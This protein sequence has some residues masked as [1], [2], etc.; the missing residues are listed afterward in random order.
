MLKQ[1][2]MAN[3]TAFNK[4]TLCFGQHLNVI[5]GENGLRKTHLLKLAYAI[6]AVSAEEKRKSK[7]SPPTKSLL[8]TRYAEKLINVFRPEVLGRLAHLKRSRECCD[9]HLRFEDSTLDTAF[10]FATNSKTEVNIDTLPTAW[11]GIAPTYLL[12][13]EL[14]TIFLNFVSAYEGHYFEFEETW[15][16]IEVRNYRIHSRTKPTE[17]PDE[18]AQ[19]I[20]DT[21][22]AL[23]PAKLPANQAD[24]KQLA[25]AIAAAKALRVVLHL[26]QPAKHSRLRL[27]AIN[28]VDVQQKLWK[29]IK[30]IDALPRVIDRSISR[31]GWRISSESPKMLTV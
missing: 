27:C 31:L 9:I 6:T 15:R 18:V 16:L 7:L 17:L 21:L 19:K 4:A 8:Q 14:L 26:E 23:L 13:R 20:F 28:P 11:V 24:E 2:N 22:S 25:K 10:G 1:L 12:T 29:L 30:S 5:V 3:F